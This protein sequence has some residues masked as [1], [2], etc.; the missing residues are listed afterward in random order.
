MNNQPEYMTK[1]EV[2]EYLFISIATLDRRVNR[3]L[4][5]PIQGMKKGWRLFRRRE[6]EALKQ[7]HAFRG[8]RLRPNKEA[9]E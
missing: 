6:V 5:T 8:A 9:S 7:R 1:R 4:L 2:C 3:G